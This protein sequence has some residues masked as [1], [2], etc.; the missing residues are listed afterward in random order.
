MPPHH[1]T[2]AL[3]LILAA[4]STPPTPIV[5]HSDRCTSPPA[6]WAQGNVGPKM[7]R[8]SNTAK[9]LGF[10][11]Q[12]W[13]FFCLTH[14]W[15]LVPDLLKKWRVLHEFH[16]PT[17]VLVYGME[18]EA[19]DPWGI[20]LWS[21]SFSECMWECASAHWEHLRL[22]KQEPYRKW[23][24]YTKD[25]VLSS[26]EDGRI[27]RSLGGKLCALWREIHSCRKHPIADH[28]HCGSLESSL[29]S[30][31]ISCP[32]PLEF[33]CHWKVHPS[34][35]GLTLPQEPAAFY[36]GVDPH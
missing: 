33:S 20:H 5:P 24:F 4:Q 7:Y 2:R 36:L 31:W 28:S 12:E 1:I 35:P 11:T 34:S 17:Q 22:F 23:E 8:L 14:W 29:H 13:T 19:Q 27:H 16:E 6:W 18:T 15:P 10:C 26:L 30:I 25:S 9:G 3:K 21:W 32:R